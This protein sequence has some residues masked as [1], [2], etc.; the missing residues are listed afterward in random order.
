MT[1]ASA[2]Q[3]RAADPHRSTWLSANAGSGK[4]SV[5]T[6][7][8][9]RLLVDG[10]A[11]ERILCLTFTTTAAAEMQNRL[12]QRLGAWALQDDAALTGALAALGLT[13]ALPAATLARARTAF[14]RAV[15]TPGGLKVQ[16]IHAFCAGLL[17]RFPLEAGVSPGF[18]E[19][20]E[21]TAQ[22]LRD[23]ITDRLAETDAALFDAAAGLVGGQ[24]M[25]GLVAEILTARA[26]FARAPDRD[27][28]AARL[29]L[30]PGTDAATLV[31]RTFAP[32]D[33]A[34]LGRLCS[35]LKS[36]STNDIKARDR[37][38]PIVGRTPDLRT[39]GTLE[40]PLLF[41]AKVTKGTPFGPKIG[42]F[43]TNPT[44]TALGPADCAALDDL[45][46]RVADARPQ[47]LALAALDR[48]LALHRFATAWLTRYD[49]AKRARGWLDFEDLITGAR[50]LLSDPSVASWVLWR[51]DGGIDHV[52]VD[53]AQDTS[54]AQ[55]DVVR[56]LTQDFTAGD[57]ARAAG[58]RTLFVVGDPKQSIYSFQGADPDA[59]ARMRTHFAGRL[60]AV[61]QALQDEHLLWSFRSSPGVLSLVDGTFPPGADAALGD[62]LDHRAFHAS[63]PGRIDLWHPETGEDGDPD[64]DWFD[65]VDLRGAAD[66][67]RRLAD[68][69][70][71]Q[72]AD[73]LA[74]PT[75]I[76]DRKTPGTPM[77]TLRAGDILILVQRRSAVFHEIIR[78]LKARGLPVAGADVLRLGGELAVQDLLATLR[79][80]ALPEDDLSLAA[81]LRSPL[82]GW[83]EDALFRLAH[84]RQG[85]LLAALRDA[86]ATH[87]DTWAILSDL[88]DR[89]DFLR[90]YDLLERLLIRHGG[91][92]RLVARLGAE[93]EDGI[94]AL[95]AQALE[96]EGAAVPSLTGFLEWIGAR[97]VSVKRRPEAAGDAIRVM[98]VHGAKGL[99]SP[100]VILPDCARRR[101]NDRART[102]RLPDGPRVALSPADQR[103]PAVAEAVAL[104]QSREAA[105]RLRLLYV[106]LT[107]AESWLIVAAAG[108]TGT[109]DDSWHAILAEGMQR[110][111][112]TPVEGGWR[113]ASGDWTEAPRD[114]GPPDTPAATDSLPVWLDTPAV[115]PPRPARPRS[116]SDLGGDKVLPGEGAQDGPAARLQ[117]TLIHR[118][119]EVLPHQPADRWDRIAATLADRLDGADPGPALQAARQVLSDPGVAHLFAPDVLVEVPVSGAV[120][121]LGPVAGVI[122][123]LVVAPDGITCVDIKS[124]ATV[125]ATPDRV[126][127]GL[128]RQMGAYLVLLQAI[129][130][131]RPV[132]V[133]ILWTRT[134]AL[135]PLPHDRVMQALA[136][137]P[138]S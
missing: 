14:A 100:V 92:K 4:T 18:T 70:A 24:D 128:L 106:A 122:D 20:D 54:P 131:D 97:E 50:R 135:M 38:A 30:S 117:G 102:V 99:E 103:P 84:P 37:I 33:A 115:T 27:D 51:L 85:Y 8:V 136:R 124:N 83:S 73:M 15:E 127:E 132:T 7:R 118:L 82:F 95:L 45:M 58:E 123:R 44:R 40:G 41:G 22:R 98:T 125:P 59:F 78:A 107:R 120:P 10:V 47:R 91:R 87:P 88:R 9:A 48:T 53:E 26:D 17:R 21:R 62:R 104:R 133:A 34:L 12:F 93:A 76:P 23:E 57:S 35:A 137:S 16:T 130:P 69:V 56:L 71:A 39:L 109:G 86:A 114:T 113:L 77:R 80:L 29:G 19:T 36:G 72:V 134:A 75:V 126:P 32:G 64:A 13:G 129:W 1:D 49:A 67:A 112:A 43:P 25:A 66:P 61:G 55:W 65:P 74:G 28:L 90:P 89:T 68:R 11:P 121:Q 96:Y 94:D 3:V 111:G 52:L 108:E 60:A 119:L 116:P 63:M 46:I 2:A 5:L 138:R 42:Q 6:A 110:L 31:A 101:L 79:V 105:E 81:A